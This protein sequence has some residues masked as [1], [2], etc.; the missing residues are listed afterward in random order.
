MTKAEKQALKRR[1]ASLS[2]EEKINKI[3]EIVIEERIASWREWGLEAYR[4]MKEG[5]E[6]PASPEL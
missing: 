3:K 5:R 4:A 1:L 2:D 6:K